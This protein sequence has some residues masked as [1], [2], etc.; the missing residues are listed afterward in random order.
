VVSANC[1]EE[2]EVFLEWLEY[3]LQERDREAVI[4]V[5]SRDES[6]LPFLQ[7]VFQKMMFLSTSLY[8]PLAFTVYLHLFIQINDK[9][10]HLKIQQTTAANSSLSSWHM[11]GK[12][13]IAR[14]TIPEVDANRQETTRTVEKEAK[15]LKRE[16]KT[17]RE[18]REERG[19]ERET[20]REI[21]G[22]DAS[23]KDEKGQQMNKS[24]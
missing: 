23:S 22:L 18:K 4:F 8:S 10:G 15:R 20:T 7:H 13:R 12:A 9:K 21:V 5:S 19:E 16:Q 11:F 6:P 2:R 14:E 17:E 1:V 3:I 24:K